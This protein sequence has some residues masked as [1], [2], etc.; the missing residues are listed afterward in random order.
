V[1]SSYEECRAECVGLHLC[2]VPEV[3]AIFGYD[4]AHLAAGDVHDVTYGNWLIMVRAGAHAQHQQHSL[5]GY[6]AT[7]SLWSAQVHTPSTSSTA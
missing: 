6:T 7:G 3:L 2:S 4:T 5:N 1:S